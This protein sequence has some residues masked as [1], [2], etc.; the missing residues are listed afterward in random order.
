M[1]YKYNKLALKIIFYT[2]LFKS[3]KYQPCKNGNKAHTSYNWIKI[4]LIVRF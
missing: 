3:L 2:P 4:T 1:Y